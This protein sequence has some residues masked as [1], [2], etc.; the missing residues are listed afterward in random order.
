MNFKRMTILLVTIIGLVR[1]ADA[2]DGTNWEK[3]PTAS[4]IEWVDGYRN[5]IALGIIAAVYHYEKGKAEKSNSYN[6][7]IGKVWPFKFKAKHLIVQITEY[8][9]NHQTEKNRDVGSV[10]R[11]I[12]SYGEIER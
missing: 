5:G 1:C 3:M 4:K 11:E 7:I 9:Q 10:I 8:Y 2:I 12:S 6:E